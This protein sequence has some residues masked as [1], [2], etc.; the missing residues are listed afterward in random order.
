MQW[1]AESTVIAH[2]VHAC[3]KAQ[4]LVVTIAKQKICAME[5]HATA[6]GNARQHL[7]LHSVSVMMDLKDQT[8]R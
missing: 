4:H 7:D 8:A 3:A 2:R 1:T 6:M 5:I